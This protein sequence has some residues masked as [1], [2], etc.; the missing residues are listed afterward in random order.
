MGPVLIRAY[1][2]PHGSNG[3]V[4]WKIKEMFCPLSEF[5][6]HVG[7]E[8]FT[9]P[10]RKATL[11]WNK[12]FFGSYEQSCYWKVSKYSE[13]TAQRGIRVGSPA[14]ISFFILFLNK[15]LQAPA[16]MYGPYFPLMTFMWYS[17]CR[18]ALRKC[19]NIKMWCS[20]KGVSADLKVRTTG[21]RCRFG[22]ACKDMMY[23][24]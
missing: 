24:F 16:M 19:F 8:V 13:N 3:K 5:E 12:I 14:S 10:F 15:C 7:A 1:C 17:E 2:S 4:C 18:Q 20:A 23:V 6:S 22:L 9:L 11:L 21:H